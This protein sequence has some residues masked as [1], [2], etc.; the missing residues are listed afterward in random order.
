MIG[1]P[2]GATASRGLTAPIRLLK[3]KFS[4]TRDSRAD[5]RG[6]SRAMHHSSNISPISGKDSLRANRRR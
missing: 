2:S 3:L 1:T 6:I 4:A 5:K